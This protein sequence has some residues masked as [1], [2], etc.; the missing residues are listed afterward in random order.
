MTWIRPHREWLTI[1]AIGLIPRCA[2]WFAA[3]KLGTPT[4]HAVAW[5]F[6]VLGSAVVIIA[7]TYEGSIDLLQRD[8][9]SGLAAGAL[10]LGMYAAL[11]IEIPFIV[12]STICH[13]ANSKSDSGGNQLPPPAYRQRSANEIGVYATL[14][15]K[16]YATHISRMRA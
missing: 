9:A 13:V 14:K 10:I 15:D 5:F 3:S 4:R 6:A 7:M 12:L 1:L 16:R 11:M 8:L 2:G